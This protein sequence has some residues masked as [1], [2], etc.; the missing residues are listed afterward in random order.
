MRTRDEWRAILGRWR[1]SGLG[2]KAFAEAEGL[3]WRTLQHWKYILGR[4]PEPERPR[5]ASRRGPSAAVS[6]PFLEVRAREVS[7]GTDAF[8]VILGGGRRVR[9]PAAFETEALRR[10]VAT[11]EE[12]P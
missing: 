6:V 9:V 8:E 1:A 5:R 2:L 10:L 3:V 7:P 12:A 11:L 4:E